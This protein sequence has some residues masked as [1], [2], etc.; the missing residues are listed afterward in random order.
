MKRAIIGDHLT[1]MQKLP[2][3]VSYH[4][5]AFSQDLIDFWQTAKPG[6]LRKQALE[7][8]IPRPGFN[9]RKLCLTKPAP[10]I[11]GSYLVHPIE[12]RCLNWHEL[13]YLLGFPNTW[14]TTREQTRS[15]DVVAGILPMT[16]GVCPN[17]GYHLSQVITNTCRMVDTP[18]LLLIDQR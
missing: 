16:R 4:P 1:N 15:A 5:K 10:T 3:G 12:P 18:E 6:P 17:V 13:R 7:L 11:L 8:E 2:A 14:E 9:A